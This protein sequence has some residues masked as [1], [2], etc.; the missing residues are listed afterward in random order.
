[1]IPLQGGYDYEGP[2]MRPWWA[3]GLDMTVEIS[4]EWTII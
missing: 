1:M 2:T 3:P 4:A